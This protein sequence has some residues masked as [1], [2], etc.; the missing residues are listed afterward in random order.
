[1]DRLQA[2]TVFSAV[3]DAKGFALAARRLSLAPSAVTRLVASLEAHLGVRLMHRTTRSL[4]LTEA[5][6]RYLE[7]VKRLLE[8]L[9]ATDEAARTDRDMPRGRLVVSA[10]VIFGR[11]HVAPLLQ[12]YMAAF[13]QVMVELDLNDRNVSLVDEG[14]DV[15][16]R[17]GGLAASGLVARRI[18]ETAKVV[19][20]TP[21]YL[22]R[23]GRPAHPRDLASHRVILFG[24]SH[25]ARQWT[26]TGRSR[27]AGGGLV[28]VDVVP[29]F[30]TNS[31]DAALAFA[32][33]GGGLTRALLYQVQPDIAAGRLV[34]VLDEFTPDPSPIQA[35]LA[36]KRMLPT[37]VRSFIDF[38]QEHARWTFDLDTIPGARTSSSHADPG[39]A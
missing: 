22:E 35:V 13:P 24:P 21:G 19:V 4:H 23:H 32:R 31:G 37:R 2:M 12:R 39:T 8:D 3:C 16:I 28:T 1:M 20:G 14:V 9:D 18:G 6:A 38:T 11:L 29:R 17:I 27:Q 30:A 36:S 26:F 33:D 25:A 15:A 7:H 34:T 10:P 5:G